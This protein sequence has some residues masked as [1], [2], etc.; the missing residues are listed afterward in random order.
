VSLCEAVSVLCR[1]KAV[2]S[3][4]KRPR[5]KRL[6]RVVLYVSNQMLKG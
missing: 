6:V 4:P 2:S 1:M 3:M 5:A